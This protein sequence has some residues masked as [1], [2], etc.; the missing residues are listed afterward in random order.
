MVKAAVQHAVE[1]ELGV[2]WVVAPIYHQPYFQGERELFGYNPWFLPNTVTFDQNNV[3][4]IRNSLECGKQVIQNSDAANGGIVQTLDAKGNW[5]SLDFTNAIRSQYPHWDG[6]HFAGTFAEER[7]VFDSGGDAYMTVN[8][9]RFSNLG[10]NLLL[11][12]TDSAR[13]WSVYE[14]PVSNWVRL[15]TPDAHHK[16]GGPPTILAYNGWT[17]SPLSLVKP[18]KAANGGLSIGAATQVVADPYAHPGPMQAGLGNVTYTHGDTT[19][20]AYLSMDPAPGYTATP[21]YIVAHNNKTGQTTSPV[22]LGLNGRD[23]PDP[24]NG[25][26]ITMDSQGYI[27]AIL[28]AHHGNFVHTRSLQPYSITDGWTSPVALGSVNS[29]GYGYYTYA[30]MVIDEDD[31]LHI[32]GRYAGDDY[33]FGL[34]YLRKKV[35]GEWENRGHLVMP[36]RSYYSTWDQK[37]T[38]DEQGRLFLRYSYFA[39]QL[40]YEGG[41]EVTAYREKWPDELIEL[42]SGSRELHGT[43]LGV[44]HHDPV[45]LMSDDGGD[46]W[47][48]ALT[49]DFVNGVVPEPGTALLIAVVV[50]FVVGRRRRCVG[51]NPS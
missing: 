33:K 18:I 13:T 8:A 9:S 32:I 35:D 44:S 51:A 37:L 4:Y 2:P 5:I 17:G 21:Q 50:P 46:S 23:E 26:A 29:N 48:I 10:R 28:G 34:D 43:W 40:D 1:P 27:H 47:R 19:Y 31:T 12:S 49:S 25:P 30:S 16:Q 14:L 3:P 11:H 36:F 7:I 15:E 22:L 6:V 42:A 41:P 24:H 20:M 39:D 38:I 45:I